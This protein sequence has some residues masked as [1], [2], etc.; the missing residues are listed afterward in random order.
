MVYSFADPKAK[1][2][3]RTQYFE[4]F[5]NRAI[6][7]DGWVAA[8]TPPILPWVVGTSIGVDEYKWEL[9]NV[10]QDFSEANNLA[11][12]EPKKLREL[13]DLFW[14]EAGKY[15][16]LP[17]DNSKVE[18]FD[19][20]LR[21]S[22]TRG[23]T[24]FTYYPGMNRIPEGSAPDLKN[25]SYRITAEVEIPASG[26]EGVLMTQGG[27]F[28]GL[29]LYLLAGKPVFYYNLVGIDRT[30][31]AGKE[32]LAPGKHSI[33]VDFK[34]DGPGIGKSA[35]AI[36]MVD[37]NTAAEGKIARTI[38]FRVSADETLDIGEDTGTPVSE[39]YH[40]PFKFTGS[41]N[42]VVINL[43][44]AKLSAAEQ[45]VLDEAAGKVLANN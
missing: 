37:G 45:K 8:T 20:G 16:V 9:Y 32:R 3:H 35:T 27:R 23:R 21:P 33:V 12:K 18:R 2:T 10:D 19:V 34:Y 14:A 42:K 36:L 25:K 7:N 44:G 5:A 41:L 40:V 17:L 13:Q 39:D 15:N 43:S 26:A 6:Y 30:S 1:S 28:N 29:G 22:L 11:A 24:E 4:M 31:V 38:P